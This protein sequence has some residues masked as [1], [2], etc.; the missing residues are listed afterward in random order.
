MQLGY[1]SVTKHIQ[2]TP[3]DH[4]RPALG[5]AKTRGNRHYPLTTTI[6]VRESLGMRS[7]FPRRKIARGES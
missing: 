2:T 5:I 7:L 6:I 4:K 1:F 3:Y